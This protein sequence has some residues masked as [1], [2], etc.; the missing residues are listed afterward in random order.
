MVPRW[1]LPSNALVGGGDDVWTLAGVYPVLDTGGG[2]DTLTFYEA[3]I[4]P[5]FLKVLMQ[6][7]FL[8]IC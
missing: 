3:I 8:S 2:D 1:S 4:L 6:L 5:S 7:H